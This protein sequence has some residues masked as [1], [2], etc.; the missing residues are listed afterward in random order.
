M[1]NVAINRK[2]LI[3][4]KHFAVSTYFNALHINILI[5]ICRYRDD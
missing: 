3:S 4:I 1:Q 5:N 2:C